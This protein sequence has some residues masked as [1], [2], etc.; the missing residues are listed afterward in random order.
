M[1]DVD[2]L[3]H[4]DRL[5]FEISLCRHRQVGTAIDP[6]INLIIEL[7]QSFQGGFLLAKGELIEAFVE[8]LPVG[9]HR[10]VSLF[11]F[12]DN[13]WFFLFPPGQSDRGSCDASCAQYWAPLSPKITTLC[14]LSE[15]SASFVSEVD[16][17]RKVGGSR[18]IFEA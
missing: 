7:E 2:A 15:M 9:H 11:S 10:K 4:G 14:Q 3:G 6:F 8:A 16:Q 18:M 12:G 17:M 13:E 1:Q 5:E